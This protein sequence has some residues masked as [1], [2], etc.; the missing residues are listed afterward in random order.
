MK[1]IFMGT[2]DFS[3][4]CLKS[5]ISNNYEIICV[6]TKPDKQVGRGKKF[7]FSD[8]KKYCLDNN[9]KYYQPEHLKDNEYINI[10]KQCSPDLIVTAS[11]GCILPTS[12]LNIPKYKCINVH[13][14][15]LPKYRGSSPIQ[16]ARKNGDSTTGVTIMYMDEK[17][18]TGD[19][20]LQK[21]IDILDDDTS[22]DLFEKLSIVSKDALVEAIKLIEKNLVNPVKQNEL[23]ATFTKIIKKEDAYLNFSYD[24]KKLHNFIMAYNPWPICYCFYEQ[25]RLKVFKSKALH[26]THNEEVGTILDNRRFLIACGNNTVIEFLDVLI[27]N[28]KRMSGESFIIGRNINKK[29]ILN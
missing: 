2:G 15:L 27:E 24:A 4:K 12:I 18:D 5:L 19:I 6:F 10:I 28:G 13:T 29:I 16:T 17:L 23:D 20:I 22:Y 26:L 21:K 3:L 8:V 25:K 1:I 7:V 9:I 11:Y 14:S